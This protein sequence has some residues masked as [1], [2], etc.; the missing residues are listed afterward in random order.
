M[1]KNTALTS[2]AIVLLVAAVFVSMTA[3][4]T[5]SSTQHSYNTNKS[6][7]AAAEAGCNW[8]GGDVIC[9]PSTKTIEVGD[10]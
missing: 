4:I 6:R 7:V 10:E 1:S 2:V 5:H 3:L 9:V 8:S